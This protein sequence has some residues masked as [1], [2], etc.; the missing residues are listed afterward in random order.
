MIMSKEDMQERAEMLRNHAFAM[1]GVPVP[2]HPVPAA[3]VITADMMGLVSWRGSAGAVSYSVQ[4]Q[5]SATAPWETIC[6]KCATD[7][8]TPWPDPKPVGLFGSHYRV[9]AYN[10]D[11]VASEPSAA[12]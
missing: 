3:P 5:T 12:R 11:G 4:R 6:D 8:D 9:I 10:A 7:A 2:P 1:Q